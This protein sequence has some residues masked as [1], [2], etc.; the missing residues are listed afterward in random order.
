M[1]APPCCCSLPFAWSEVIWRGAAPPS[2]PRPRHSCRVERGD[3]ERALPPPSLPRPRHSLDPTYGGLGRAAPA[4]S[5]LP[6]LWSLT[7]A[8]A[9]S[10]RS[11]RPTGS[12]A[13]RSHVLVSST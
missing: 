9:S 10:S 11:A 3:L 7:R 5:H 1:L 13:G 8:Q 6:V 2:L 12:G 4:P